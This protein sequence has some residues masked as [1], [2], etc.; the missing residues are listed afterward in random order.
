MRHVGYSNPQS[1]TVAL[2]LAVHGIVKISSILT[3]DRYE[4]SSSQIDTT[5]L[6]VSIGLFAQR[7]RLIE[8]RVGPLP[9]DLMRPYGNINFKPRV[10]VV[11]QNFFH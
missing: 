2:W 8:H 3:I 6:V 5:T 11:T 9:R 1:K 10:E 7:R 4:G